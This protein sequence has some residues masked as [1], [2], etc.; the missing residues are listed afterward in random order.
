MGNGDATREL[1]LQ[2]LSLEYNSLRQE[3]VMRMDR[4]Y[5]TVTL[6]GAAAALVFG[7][8]P[9]D[10][11][12]PAWMVYAVSVVL[13]AAG[14]G[15]WWHSGRSVGKLSQRVAWLEHDI[16]QVVNLTA[17]ESNSGALRWESDQQGRTGSTRCCSDKE[18]G[19]PKTN[20]RRP[21]PASASLRILSGAPTCRLP[22]PVKSLC[23]GR[24]LKV[25]V[26]P[27]G[28]GHGE[29]FEGLL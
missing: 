11:N 16:N 17:A 5:Q 10:S 20:R 24:S 26:A 23:K 21:D 29:P 25:G 14:I 9:K 27:V 7:F 22:E 2:A 1:K 12:L 4:R 3:I 6:L 19:R 13:L 8:A 15:S 28:V 18:S